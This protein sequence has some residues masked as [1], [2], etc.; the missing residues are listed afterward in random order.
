MAGA[1]VIGGARRFS[2]MEPRCDQSGTVSEVQ[3]DVTDEHQVRE[4]FAAIGNID[5]LVNNAGI[6]T[7]APLWE[8]SVA[9]LREMLEVHVVGTFLCCR[10]ALRSMRQRGN[11]HIVNIGS[12]AATQTFS[13]CS[14]YTAAK[15]GQLGLSR[16]LREELRDANVRV[17][18]VSPGAVDTP[19]WDDRPGFDRTRMIQAQDLAEFI[20]DIVSRPA[21][22]VE[23]VLVLPPRGNL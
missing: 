20:V 13:S 15:A 4:R 12:V 1:R 9:D 23:E 7:F 10:E 11:G 8:S 5:V 21:M 19:I 18:C 6:G 3:L 22:S 2:D 14:G 17:T 16:V